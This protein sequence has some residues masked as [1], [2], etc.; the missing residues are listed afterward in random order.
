MPD[1]TKRNPD[2]D[3]ILVNR[4]ALPRALKSPFMDAAK[5]SGLKGMY[6]ETDGVVIIRG[7]D[8]NA[9]TRRGLDIVPPVVPLS[10][11]LIPRTVDDAL[12][13][14]TVVVVEPISFVAAVARDALGATTLAAKESVEP[15]SAVAKF[16]RRG[17]SPQRADKPSGVAIGRP[18]RRRALE[19]L[20]WMLPFVGVCATGLPSL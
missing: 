8:T 14:S 7:D 3:L 5:G 11:A 13:S 2:G 6:D 4:E 15:Q 16:L 10:A 20:V 1:S 9:A 19:P 12:P 17:G 18:P